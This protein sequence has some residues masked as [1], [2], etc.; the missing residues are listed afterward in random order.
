[1]ILTG[2]SITKGIGIGELLKTD[3]PISFLGCVD[4][5]TGIIIDKSHPL[6][7]K[8]IAGKVLA[9]PHGKGSTVGSYVLYALSKNNTAPKAII[10]IECETIIA[11]GAVIAG[12]PVV[13][14]LNG[15]LPDNGTEVIVNGTDGT[16]SFDGFRS[17]L[18]TK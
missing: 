11:T 1:M 18:H 12:I 8:S 5:Q 10:N 13:D 16:I 17:L 14:Q 4:P 9:F 7:G 15:N 6:Y 3:A 2:R